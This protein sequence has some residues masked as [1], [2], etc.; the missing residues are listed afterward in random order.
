MGLN[1][2]MERLSEEGKAYYRTTVSA[3]VPE[4]NI[5]LLIL[6]RFQYLAKFPQFV[7][8]SLGPTVCLS[9]QPSIR[10]I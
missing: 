3:R 8:K 5:H 10:T 4:V 2:F 9:L 1:D 6:H 7:A